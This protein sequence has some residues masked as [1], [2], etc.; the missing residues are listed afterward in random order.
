MKRIV[1]LALC[2]ISL[3][4]QDL[5]S[6]RDAVALCERVVQLMESTSVAAPGLAQAGAPVLENA[7]QGLANLR[8]MQ[9]DSALVYDFLTNTRA[10]LAVSDLV[11]KPFPFPEEGRRQF[12]ELREAAQRLD[13]HFRALLEQKERAIRHPDRDSLARYAEANEKLP[14]PSP[15]EPRIV[16]LGDSITDGWRLNEYF[17]G[18]D[19]VNRGIGGQIT[20]QMLARMLADVVERQPKAVLVLGG[21]ND[22]AR[23]VPLRTIQNNLT[24]IADL[25][26]HHKIAPIFASI[27]PVSDYHRKV[28]DR[29]NPAQIRE[30]NAWL[31]SFCARRNFRYVDYFSALVDQ[32]GFL[33]KEL[34]GDG[35][36]PNA[37]GYRR[38][39]PVALQV[40]DE[41]I[42]AQAPKSKRKR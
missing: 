1:I 30:L 38:M 16:F 42:Q 24:M 20:S 23:G 22:L 36:H 6:N 4:A 7:R 34:S 17:P 31:K 25:A 8:A 12:A 14:P 2:A 37:A 41:V 9:G 18:R 40:I 21:T 13:V 29:R 27:L 39:A 5:L 11:P 3:Q 15:T 35:L 33:G 19:F 28:T 32:A 10:Y 26:E